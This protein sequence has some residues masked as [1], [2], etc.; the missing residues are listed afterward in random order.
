MRAWGQFI[1][2]RLLPPVRYAV[3]MPAV[4][5][6]QSRFSA[7]FRVVANVDVVDAAIVRR[8]AARPAVNV[9]VDA[10]RIPLIS[11]AL[12]DLCKLTRRVPRTYVLWRE[13]FPSVEPQAATIWEALA[14]SSAT[15]ADVRTFPALSVGIPNGMAS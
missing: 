6:P 13:L 3:P 4:S 1:G 12:F 5:E 8:I 2:G 10:R 11:T 14:A 7:A 15:R 9:R